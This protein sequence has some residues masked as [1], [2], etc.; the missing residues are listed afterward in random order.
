MRSFL[1]A[2]EQ[3]SIEKFTAQEL[4]DENTAIVVEDE[5]ESNREDFVV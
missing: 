1:E 4:E 3:P 5:K 2:E